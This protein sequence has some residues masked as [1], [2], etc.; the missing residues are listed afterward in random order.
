MDALRLAAGEYL[1]TNSDGYDWRVSPL[2]ATSL[3]GLPPTVISTA[4]FDPLRDEGDAYAG[5]LRD[6]GV[7]VAHFPEPGM[8]HGYFRLGAVSPAAESARLRACAAFKQ[9]LL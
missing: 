3:Q 1:S 4:E 5:V 8:I 7:E 2:R 6:A 9:M